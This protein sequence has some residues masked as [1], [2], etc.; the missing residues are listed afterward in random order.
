MKIYSTLIIL[1]LTAILIGTSCTKETSSIIPN[2][3]RTIKFILYTKQDFSN[4]NHNI[5]FSLFI[6]NH[7]RDLFDSALS[8]MKIKDI[9]DSMHKLI[10]EKKVPNDDGSDLA[11]GFNYTIENVGISWY[12]D[13]CAA[14]QTFKVV[15]FSFQ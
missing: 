9:P 14:G 7:T 10:F 5:T 4:D 13:T 11:A 15:D 1:A 3:G 8:S 6:R 12:I 2:S